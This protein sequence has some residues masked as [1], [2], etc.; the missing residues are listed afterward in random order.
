MLRKCMGIHVCKLE[1][2]RISKNLLRNNRKFYNRHYFQL[3]GDFFE[4]PLP[5]EEICYSTFCH[6]ITCIRHCGPLRSS[7]L[8]SNKMQTSSKVTF[9]LQWL[10]FAG[11]HSTPISN[12]CHH[13]NPCRGFLLLLNCVLSQIAR[14]PHRI[15]NI[16]TIWILQ[17]TSK[18]GKKMSSSY[19]TKLL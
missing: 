10:L 11:Y 18:I 19:P 16:E 5:G 1:G 17:I 9:T 2:S 15:A 13:A 3:R 12:I 14:N 8:F 7:F 4:R 6:W